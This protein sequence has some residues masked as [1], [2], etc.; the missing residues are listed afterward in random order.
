MFKGLFSA[1]IDLLVPPRHSDALV[2]TLTLDDLHDLQRQGGLPYHSEA[3]RA[4]VW[5]VKYFAN[6]AAAALGG[7]LLAEEITML[8]GEEF[9]VP[10]VVP[11][12]M[13]PARRKVR[14][15]NQT[16]VL[17]AAALPLLGGAAECAP[18]ALQ[19]VVD[20]PTQQGLPRAT[21]L[22]NVRDSM[23]ADPA[24]V[25]DRVCIVVDD[26]TTTGAT[27]TEAKRAL[28]AAGAGSVHCVALAYS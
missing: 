7:A 8:A 27:L 19:R 21:R 15:H 26:V 16:E 3:V 2:R 6:P 9:G 1:W 11:V 18:R 20:T 25:K 22:N 4:L 5:E 10:L 14:G 17:C 13:H 28:K 24:V 12:P 23:R